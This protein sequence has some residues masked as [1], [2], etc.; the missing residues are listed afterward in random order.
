MYRHYGRILIVNLI[1]QQ[2]DEQRVGEE[3]RNLFFLLVKNFQSK[4]KKEKSILSCLSEKD[5]T[6]FDYHEQAKANKT[7]TPELLVE[8]FL[9][10]NTQYPIRQELDRLDVFSYSDEK[11]NSL[12][13]G[14]LRINCIDCLDRTNNVQ[15]AI[16]I[17]MLAQQLTSL[18]KPAQ[19]VTVE[20][21]LKELWINNGDHISRIYTGTGA[22][23]QRNKVK[24]MDRNNHTILSRFIISLG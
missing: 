15:L 24:S 9:I 18:N 21:H 20:E 16:G 14:V 3:Y 19:S 17:Y 22:I 2:N 8:K 1:G 4:Q 6:W 5:F 12:Q 11:V 10:R 23:G 13:K 7:L